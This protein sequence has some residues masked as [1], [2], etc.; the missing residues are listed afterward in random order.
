MT[1]Y[2]TPLGD[3]FVTTT[4]GNH[5]EYQCEAGYHVE[6]ERESGSKPECCRA[7]ERTE[8]KQ[9]VQATEEPV[10]AVSSCGHDASLEEKFASWIDQQDRPLPSHEWLEDW[11]RA[12]CDEMSQWTVLITDPPGTGKMAGVCL[13]SKHVRRTFLVC[14]MRE[15]EERKLAKLI[16]KGQRG[17]RQ[18]LVAIFNIDTDVTD[19]LKWRLCKAA[20]QSQIPLISVCDDG[21]VTARDDLDQKCLCLEVQHELRNVEQPLLQLTQRNDLNM[22]ETCLSIAIACGHDVRKIINTAQLL[23][24]RSFSGELPTVD[25]SAPAACHQL[26]LPGNATD[27]TEMLELPEQDGEELCRALQRLYTT[28][29]GDSFETLDQCAFAVEVMALGDLAE[30]AASHTA[31]AE[32]TSD[33]ATNEFYLGVVSTLRK[34]R[35]LHSAQACP[36]ESPQT[37]QV[38]AVLIAT[39]SAETCLSKGRIEQPLGRSQSR[40]AQDGILLITNSIP[41]ELASKAVAQDEAGE[42]DRTCVKIRTSKDG[43]MNEERRNA[44]NEVEGELVRSDDHGKTRQEAST[45]EACGWTLVVEEYENILDDVTFADDVWNENAAVFEQKYSLDIVLALDANDAASDNE[46]VKEAETAIVEG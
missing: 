9:P 11:S 4:Y 44:E 15:V 25:L 43:R 20:Q 38:S 27:V 19:E 40:G 31:W 14:D 6:S 5:V 46:V 30:C 28:S 13:L 41:T 35:C 24:Q 34:Q 36:M 37:N 3:C 7:N 23:G 39:L 32:D 22:S 1:A 2:A 18:T 17:L 12:R 42:L 26:L 33:S 10:D 21:V 8:S 16:M 29:C 45:I